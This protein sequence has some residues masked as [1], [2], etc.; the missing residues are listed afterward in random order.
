MYNL[1]VAVAHRRHMRFYHSI[2]RS[3]GRCVGSVLSMEKNT[4]IEFAELVLLWIANLMGSMWARQCNTTGFCGLL[5]S[6][7]LL[8]ILPKKNIEACNYEIKKE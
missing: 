2:F 4:E 7:Y 6:T 5:T 3:I 1:D 8:E